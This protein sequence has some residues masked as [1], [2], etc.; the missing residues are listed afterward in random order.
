MYVTSSRR[1]TPTGEGKSK[2]ACRK[3]RLVHTSGLRHPQRVWQP[4]GV[5]PPWHGV[6]LVLLVPAV[7]C[8]PRDCGLARE[9]HPVTT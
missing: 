6:V 7:L 2:G 9:N 5:T 8:Q 1:S 4:F 3:H